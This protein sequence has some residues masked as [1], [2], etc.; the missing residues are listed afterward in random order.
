MMNTPPVAGRRYI[1]V[2][3]GVTL[4]IC[5]L[6]QDS[7]PV[8]MAVKGVQWQTP[9][10]N[11]RVSR[12]FLGRRISPVHSAIGSPAPFLLGQDDSE[13][14]NLKGQLLQLACAMD[15]GQLYNP[16]RSGAYKDR[17]EAAKGIMEKLIDISPPLPT[18]LEAL[19]GE[20]ELVYTSV[21]YGIFRSSPFFLAIQ[22][23][24]GNDTAFGQK[25]AELFFKLHELQTC[26][27]GVST[28]G[29]VAQLVDSKKGIL[30]S[31][32]DTT[33][34]GLTTIPIIGWFKL[35]PTFGGCV[36]TVANAEM[37]EDARINMEVDYTIVKPI[38]GLSGWVPGRLLFNR[39]FPVNAVWQ[40]LPWNWG[41]KP[42]C[43]VK[44]VYL[45][46]NFRIVQD[47]DGELFAYARPVAPRPTL[48]DAI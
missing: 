4:V 21:K 34:F 10:I 44:V 25:S 3:L 37:G 43:S 7:A 19:D 41:R 32:F 24:F 42:K 27:W 40:I 2:G 36:I 5:L 22:E 6:V 48:V 29:R 14:A 23:A 17:A 18:S 47:T 16:Q 12:Q 8:G 28:I 38:E 15:R 1:F 39:R 13:R 26:S 45:D 20:W 46:D 30:A 33:I 9:T 11:R 35:L 31:E